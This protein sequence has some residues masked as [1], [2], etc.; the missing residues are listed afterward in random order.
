MFSVSIAAIAM[1]FDSCHPTPTIIHVYHN[2]PN[3][4]SGA[5]SNRLKVVSNVCANSV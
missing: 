5:D 2:F 1:T 3:G 4:W